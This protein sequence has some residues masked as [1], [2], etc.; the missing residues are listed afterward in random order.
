[1]ALTLT[2]NL[3]IIMNGKNKEKREISMNDLVVEVL[4]NQRENA[5]R[6]KMPKKSQPIRVRL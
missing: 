6:A 3:Y 4:E 1:M 2:K 5:K